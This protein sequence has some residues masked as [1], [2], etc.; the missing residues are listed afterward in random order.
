MDVVGSCNV[1]LKNL[2]VDQAIEEF[3]PLFNSN[4]MSVGQLQVKIAWSDSKQDEIG[5]GT[6]MTRVWEVELY[7]KIAENL[8]QRGLNIDNSFN[9]FDQDNDGL[10]SA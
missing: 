9:I 4:G 3:C 10:I 5:Y 2:V 7:K 6:P 8:K 1:Q